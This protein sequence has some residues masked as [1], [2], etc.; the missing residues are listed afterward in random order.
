MSD[1]MH[2]VYLSISS[3]SPESH[4]A[5]P[6]ISLF[7]DM[8]SSYYTLYSI[9]ALLLHFPALQPILLLTFNF[10]ICPTLKSVNIQ[11][12]KMSRSVT[13]LLC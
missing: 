3:R 6:P 11:H 9:T 12:H 13:N 8:P 10:L 1:H 7:E 2:L 4:L 5:Q